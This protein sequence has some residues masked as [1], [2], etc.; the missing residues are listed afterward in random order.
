MAPMNARLLRPL[1]TGFDPRR[2]AGLGAWFDASDLST[3]S[4]TSDGTTPVMAND[5]PVAYWNCKATGTAIT[6]SIDANRP[7]WKSASAIGSKPGLD[8]DGSNDYL[9]ATSGQLMKMARSVPGV[10]VFAV[11]RTDNTNT[12]AWWHVSVGAGVNQFRG[13]LTGVY[14]GG[15][16]VGGR[17]LDADTLQTVATSALNTTTN[18][19]LRETLDYAN[20]DL[21]AHVNGVQGATNASF[22]TAGNSEDSDSSYVM[23]GNQFNNDAFTATVSGFA[24]TLCEWIAYKRALAAAESAR[25]E[26]YLS[27]KYGIA[28]S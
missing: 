22:Q 27:N 20:S 1:A 28:L 5:D 6:Q 23:L 16:Q 12:R 21:F 19:I 10:T 17:R 25:V 7:L 4:Q 13:R 15:F 24:G 2:I 3:L 9:F 18:Y 11:L 14:N 26:R 8:F